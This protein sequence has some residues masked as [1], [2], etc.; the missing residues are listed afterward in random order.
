[1]ILTEATQP[2]KGIPITLEGEVYK[3]HRA[4]VEVR[5]VSDNESYA[6]Y[7][8]YD[9]AGIKHRAKLTVKTEGTGNSRTNITATLEEVA[10]E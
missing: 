7:E 9:N 4:P 2:I 1:M 6:I 10:I 8:G 5:K 3:A